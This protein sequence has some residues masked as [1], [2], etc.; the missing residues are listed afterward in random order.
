MSTPAVVA[1]V[2]AAAAL[3]AAAYVFGN[4][5]FTS[6][7]V[8]RIEARRGRPLPPLDEQLD[9]DDLPLLYCQRYKPPHQRET[10]FERTSI[11]G[12]PLVIGRV[13]NLVGRKTSDTG[14]VAIAAV[15][16][17]WPAFIL[18]RQAVAPHARGLG[19]RLALG[20]GEAERLFDVRC[21]DEAFA[22]RLLTPEVQA[23]LL[24]APVPTYVEAG[25]GVAIL[26][27]ATTRGRSAEEAGSFLDELLS[28]AEGAVG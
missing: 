2:V 26:V 19:P 10:S 13:E 23:W 22:R 4:R 3:M 5:A 14:Y 27:L 11:D 17:T 20:L 6:A 24:H 7:A 9:L 8:R 15:P 18:N 21:H 25:P 28:L 12:R 16:P 1:I